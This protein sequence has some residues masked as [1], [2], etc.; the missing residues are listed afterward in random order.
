MS[1][2]LIAAAGQEARRLEHGFIGTEHLLLALL[3]AGDPNILAVLDSAG[4]PV[5]DAEARLEHGRR[6]RRPPVQGGTDGEPGLT[7]HARRALEAAAGDPARLVEGM[8]ADRGSILSRLVEQ[9]EPKAAPTAGDDGPNATAD[10]AEA[11][12]PA[13]GRERQPKK[14][15]PPRQIKE[16]APSPAREPRAPREPQ[17]SKR[18]S[19]QEHAKTPVAPR[20]DTPEFDDDEPFV[21]R[22]AVQPRKPFAIPWRMLLLL[23]VPATIAL[24]MSGSGPLV[25]FV[26]ACLGVLP[27]AS[28]MGEAT[29]HLAARTGPTL[30]G[31]LNATFGNAAELII[32]IVA[33]RA[34]MIELVKASIAGSILG[35]LLLILGLSLLAGGINRPVLRFNRTSVGMSAAMLALAVV[36]LVFP[37]LLHQLHPRPEE[38]NAFRMSEAAAVILGI[39]YLCSLLFSLKTHKSLFDGEHAIP[40]RGTWGFGKAV[41]VL[42]LA[43]LGVVVQSEILVHA[44]QGVTTTLGWSELFLGLI[45]IPII[46]NAAEH[47]TAIMVARKGQIDLALQIALG[48]STQIALLVA[49]ILVGVGL[50]VGQ[51]M[52]LVF[53]PLEVVALGMA[54]IVTAIITLDGESHWFEGVQL[55]AVY[56]LLAAAAWFI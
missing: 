19:G 40:A 25:L 15:R 12:P 11:S 38:L 36:G 18:G 3:K 56:S 42:G 22:L 51:P 9:S 23:L 55:L 30:G 27:L 26:V 43:T 44:V 6:G 41:V 24:N 49:P 50:I 10:A 31:L 8:R 5:A 37:A 1:E 33:L 7:S 54:T 17:E 4:I 2:A 29:E 14:E 34:G 46:G 16:R 39:T 47:S 21:P 52:D 32:A 45:I 20:R 53:R 13:Q 48:S 28:F 35:N